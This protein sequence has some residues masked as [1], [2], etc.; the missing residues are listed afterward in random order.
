MALLPQTLLGIGYSVYAAALW[1]SIPYCVNPKNLGTA[2]GL[3]TAFQ[4]T[5]LVLAPLVTGYLID[6]TGPVGEENGYFW[7]MMAL[8]GFAAIGFLINLWLYTDDIKNRGSVLNNVEKEDS[9]EALMT[10]P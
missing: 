9:L 4:N 6:N 2:F 3:T 7:S 1:G 10:T 8:A 5:G